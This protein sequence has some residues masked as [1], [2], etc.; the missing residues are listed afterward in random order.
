MQSKSETLRA[1]ISAPEILVMPGIFDGYSAR[2]VARSGFAAGFI[3]GAGVSEASLGWV[4][5][6]R[7]LKL[8]ESGG[9]PPHSKKWVADCDRGSFSRLFLVVGLGF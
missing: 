4:V 1:L 7:D 9:Q 5:L 8:G 2:I 6:L 3:T